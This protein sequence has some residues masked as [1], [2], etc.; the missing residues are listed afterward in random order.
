MS[1]TTSPSSVIKHLVISSGGPC[2]YLMY[3]AAKLLEKNN[4]WKH[5]NIKSIYGC[6]IGTWLSIPIALKYDWDTLDTY[7]IKRPF[8]K[9]FFPKSLFDNKLNQAMKIIMDKG[10]M[11]FEQFKETLRPLL[12]AKDLSINVSMREFYEKT[13]VELHFFTTEV[14]RFKYIDISYKTHPDLPLVEASYMSCSI[15]YFAQPIIR[16]GCCFIDGAFMSAYPLNECIRGQGCSV[17]EVLGFNILWEKTDQEITKDTGVFGYIFALTTQLSYYLSD[18]MG[19]LTVKIPNQVL[20]SPDLCRNAKDWISWIKDENF[21]RILIERGETYGKIFLSYK[22]ATATLAAAHSSSST[23]ISTSTSSTNNGE[24]HCDRE[25]IRMPVTPLSLPI[26]TNEVASLHF[27]ESIDYSSI[28][29]ANNTSNIINT[30][31]ESERNS[32]EGENSSECISGN[33]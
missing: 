5:E 13:G 9:I 11:S 4:I 27:D 31:I 1:E 2:G 33:E 7:Y 28:N 8:E 22:Q 32:E 6:S 21:R 25:D 20:C 30:L 17:D 16:D 24:D 26:T 10:F 15:P 29:D 23:Y 3:G 18:K 12:V 14:N 19:E